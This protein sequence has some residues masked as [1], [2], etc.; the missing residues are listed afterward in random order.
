[1][2]IDAKDGTI[3][4]YFKKGDELI[5]IV[6]KNSMVGIVFD[7][8]KYQTV[9]IVGG[10]TTNRIKNFENVMTVFKDKYLICHSKK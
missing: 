5:Q 6:K 2:A 8:T 10:L 9:E 3:L 1:M 4:G 7:P